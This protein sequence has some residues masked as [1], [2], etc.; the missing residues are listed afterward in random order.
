L[1]A[2]SDSIS[3]LAGPKHN[4]RLASEALGMIYRAEVRLKRLYPKVNR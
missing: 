4:V 3:L 1:R 2:N